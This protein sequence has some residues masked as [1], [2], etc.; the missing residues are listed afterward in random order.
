MKIKA[1]LKHTDHRPWELPEK[2]WKFY[3]EWKETIFLHWQVSDDELRKLV[4]PELE[5][6]LFEGKPWVSV[7]A[8]TMDNI[9]PRYLPAF[10]PVSHF[11]ELNVRTYVK[12]GTKT[13]VYFLSM[14]GSKHLSCLVAKAASGL[15]YRYSAME[16]A[17]GFF[18]SKNKE[19]KE[20]FSVAYTP[21][22]TITAKDKLLTWLTERYALF[23]YT[24]HSINKFEVHHPAWPV[25]QIAIRQLQ[26][27]Y[28]RFSRLL[29]G[30]PQLQ[31]YSKGVQVVAWGKEKVQTS[32]TTKSGKLQINQKQ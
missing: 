23:Q 25:Q 19:N 22:A 32:R 5:L 29:A 26:L 31:H 3:Q 24:R 16:R 21:G 12:A 6:D 8:F 30:P 4:P 9:R 10:P 7:V 14:E 1:L 20:H 15:P 28:P 17:A 18:H 2:R 11:H 27:S 13:G